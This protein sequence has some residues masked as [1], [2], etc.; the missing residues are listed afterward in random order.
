MPKALKGCP[1]YKK[2]PHLVTLH[3]KHMSTSLQSLNSAQNLV[4]VFQTQC[5]R[6]WGIIWIGLINKSERFFGL[7][8]YVSMSGSSSS[9]SGHKN[10]NIVSV[11]RLGDFLEFLGNKFYYKSSPNFGWRLGQ[12]WKALLFKSN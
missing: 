11:T 12:L 8:L 7:F 1:K 10:H 4:F 6:L 5:L 9:G 2:S 3:Q